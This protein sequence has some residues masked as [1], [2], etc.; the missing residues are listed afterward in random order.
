GIF[1]L[2]FETVIRL[3]PTMFLGALVA[4]V[5]TRTM[6]ILPS[7]MMHLVNNG[8]ALLLVSRPELQGFLVT[9]NGGPNPVVIAV[10]VVL[11]GVGVRMLPSAPPSPAGASADYKQPEAA[12][13][14]S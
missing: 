9:A 6:S 12:P 1:H 7:M 5:A 13:A 3:F 4:L 2:S 14:V 10:G 11:L 8:T